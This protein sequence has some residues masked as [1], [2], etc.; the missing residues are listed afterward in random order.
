MER[1][2]II[3][4]FVVAVGVFFW[5]CFQ[6]RKLPQDMKDSSAMVIFVS[7]LWPLMLMIYIAVLPFMLLD[8][9]YRKI[10]GKI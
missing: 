7:A 8:A 9:L 2:P 4:W 10:S 5:Q 1:A 3:V 6:E